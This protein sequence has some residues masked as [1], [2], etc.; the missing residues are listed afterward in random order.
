MSTAVISTF[1]SVSFCTVCLLCSHFLFS[2]LYLT[3][4]GSLL[5]IFSR[6]YNNHCIHP[7][8]HSSEEPIFG[9]LAKGSLHEHSETSREII[10]CMVIW[11]WWVLLMLLALCCFAQSN[12]HKFYFEGLGF[13][14]W[15]ADWTSAPF[16]GSLTFSGLKPRGNANFDVFDLLKRN[17][18]RNPPGQTLGMGNYKNARN[19]LVLS[20]AFSPPCEKSVFTRLKWT[21]G[22]LWKFRVYF[23]LWW[24]LL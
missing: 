9:R 24:P 10:D 2:F 8:W 18:V 17:I 6:F 14:V 1:P 19:L 15:S 11:R 20:P 5:C 22:A 23:M 21:V 3:S 13:Q 7:D 4:V 16:V 12:Q